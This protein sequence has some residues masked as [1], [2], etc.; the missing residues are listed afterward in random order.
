MMPT[1]YQVGLLQESQFGVIPSAQMQLVNVSSLPMRMERDAQRPNILT[2]S[3]RPYPTRILRKS[4]TL[5]LPMPLQ[6]DNDLI[7][8]RSAMCSDR[9]S[10]VTVTNTDIE[11]TATAITS[12]AEEFDN[13]QS[14]DMVFV[15]GVGAGVN[16]DKWFGPV[17][18]V[19]DG[20]LTVPPGQLTVQAAGGSVTIR[21]RRWTDGDLEISFAA[22]WHAT[23]L[24]NKFRRSPGNIV[25]A[26]RFEW[27]QGS[28]AT[29]EYTCMSKVP[30]YQAA[31]MGT[32]A[33]LAAPDS[34]FMESCADFQTLRV[35][36][37][38]GALITAIVSQLRFE[39]ASARPAI[40]GLGDEGPSAF[41]LGSVAA[42]IDG[43]AIYDDNSHAIAA[44]V[45]AQETLTVTWDIKDP[46]GNRRCYCLPALSADNG[47]VEIGEADSGPSTLPF[48][49][50][51]HDPS[52]DEDSYFNTSIPYVV[53][54]FDVPAA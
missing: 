1:Y 18:K 37:S 30:E 29:A 34:D 52:K 43:T 44:A 21:T 27:Q 17:V 5:T 42:S 28:W 16:A 9:G 24:S 54:V 13:L 50:N 14:G 23:K 25:T 26:A 47:D 4:G 22:Q 48:R 19:D 53:G 12:V 46:Q 51:A 40:Y 20:E 36:N 39:L 11:F 38:S 49:L 41:D 3:R 7:P 6:H 8:M 35:L 31:T 45:D 33:N 32:G 10:L 2:G 15:T